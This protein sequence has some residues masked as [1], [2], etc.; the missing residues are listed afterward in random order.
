MVYGGLVVLCL[1]GVVWGL[2]FTFRG[3]LPVYWS[4]NEPVLEFPVDLLF[5]NFV[6]PLAI[7]SIKPSDGLHKAYDWWFHKCARALRLTN[8][9][10]GERKT[11]EEVH[12][13]YRS[14][15]DALFKGPTASADS[16]RD[17]PNPKLVRDGKFVR[18]PASDQVR[19]P[20][21]ENVFVEINEDNERV[22]GKPETED[23]LHGKSN[24]LFTA[25]YIPPHFRMRIAAFLIL[26]WAFA[27]ITGVGTTI[28]PLVI[29]RRMIRSFF[30]PHL[31]VND[32][33][34]LS[35]GASLVASIYYGSIY[36]H[37]HFTTFRAGAGQTKTSPA[38]IFGCLY[39]AITRALS[40]VYMFGAVAVLLPSLF[41]LV[42]E[43]YILIPLHAYLDSSQTHVIHFVQDWTLGVLYARMA[44]RYLLR[45]PN[46]TSAKALRA[47][48]RDGWA[49]P[50]V[51]L[52]TRA[53]IIPA[54]FVFSV[55]V[56]FPL[57][58][59]FILNQTVFSGA[60]SIVHSHA[61]RFSYPGFLLLAVIIF[62]IRLVQ[63]QVAIWRVAI[64]DDVYLI[65]ERLHNLGEKRAR[66]V[67]PARRILS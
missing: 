27:A 66:N 3:V 16:S 64:R 62:G 43:L 20:K 23:G 7:R 58:I 57:P 46:S 4:S 45:K 44:I 48:I 17:V 51:K 28:L 38:Q 13:S 40:L 12:H 24:E 59:G 15:R 5:Y 52:A 53:F 39:T 31:R 2:S 34:A 30:P 54:T 25:V 19:I 33:Y 32:I 1:G 49:K 50:D 61:Y 35:A 37:Q 11:D 47:I 67:G 56:F 8:F 6:M 14:L 65:G 9:L 18:A 63:R 29:G 60:E 41:S 36:L 26:L 55:A 42:M 22:D 10:F 21:G